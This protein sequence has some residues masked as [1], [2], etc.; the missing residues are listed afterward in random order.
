MLRKDVE[1]R[2]AVL[3]AP[4]CRDNMSEHQFGSIVVDRFVE[5]ERT[6]EGAVGRYAEIYEATRTR[7]EVKS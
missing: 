2:Q 7:F 3:L 1:H 4:T 5:T 6:W